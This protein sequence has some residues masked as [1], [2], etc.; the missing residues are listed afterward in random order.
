MPLPK[1][2]ESESKHEFLIRCMADDKMLS[3]YPDATQRFA[4][5]TNEFTQPT[6]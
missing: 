6:K 5:C 1:P 2:K 4:V 3:E